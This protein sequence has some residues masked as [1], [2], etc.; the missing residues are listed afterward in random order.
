MRISRGRDQGVAV[1]PSPRYLPRLA[2]CSLTSGIEQETI[3]GLPLC[4]PKARMQRSARPG[5]GMENRSD[6]PPSRHDQ[7]NS[8]NSPRFHPLCPIAIVA[9]FLLGPD[10]LGDDSP[11]T[12]HLRSRAKSGGIISVSEEKAVSWT[13]AKPARS[14]GR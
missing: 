2:D 8:M 5:R 9:S 10:A 7:D 3:S 13:P 11:L 6:S 1:Q 4:R 14:E 12:L